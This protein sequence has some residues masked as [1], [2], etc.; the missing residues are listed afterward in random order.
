M[1]RAGRRSFAR[2]AQP[3]IFT[4][5]IAGLFYFWEEGDGWSILILN[6]QGRVSHVPELSVEAIA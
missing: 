3:F 5:R 1:L 6:L 4:R 2:Q